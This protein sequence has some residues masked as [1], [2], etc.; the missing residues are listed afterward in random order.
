MVSTNTHSSRRGQLAEFQLL[1]NP[2]LENHQVWSTPRINN[3][4]NCFWRIPGKLNQEQVSGILLA[5]GRR[6]RQS[7]V[8]LSVKGARKNGF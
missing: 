6:L 1:K 2:A 7:K 4:Y 8:C 5:L 3:K